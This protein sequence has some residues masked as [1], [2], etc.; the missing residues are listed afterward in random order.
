M[1]VRMK[2]QVSGYRDG[3]R[4]PDIGGDLS[5]SDTEGA[6]LCAQGFA[7]PVAEP[8]KP[9]RATAKRAEKRG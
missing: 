7:E 9:E 2:V 6:E 3:E 8:A 1:K 4:W 5:V